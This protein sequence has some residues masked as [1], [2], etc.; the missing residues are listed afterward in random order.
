MQ[1]LRKIIDSYNFEPYLDIQNDR[2]RKSISQ[3]RMS[4][5]RL[6][7]ETGRWQNILRKNWPN[8]LLLFMLIPATKTEVPI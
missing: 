2:H 5:H 1:L 3:I 8:F 6:A 7:I 4:R